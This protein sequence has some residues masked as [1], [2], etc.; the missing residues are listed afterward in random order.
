MFEFVEIFKVAP[1]LKWI[2]L[3]SADQ[4]NQKS[5]MVRLVVNDGPAMVNAFIKRYMAKQETSFTVSES[6]MR[7]LEEVLEEAGMARTLYTKGA[8]G[9]DLITLLPTTVVHFKY[10]EK[11]SFRK[12]RAARIKMF[13]DEAHQHLQV[14]EFEP[15]LRRLEWVHHLQPDHMTAFK[16]KIICFRSWKKMAE[17]IPVFERWIEESPDLLEPR[18]GLGEM[19]LF[20]EQNQRAKET[21]EQTLTVFPN[22]ALALIGLA[23][24]K[25]KL[26]EDPLGDLRKAHVMDPLATKDLIEGQFDFRSA[27]PKDLQPMTLV[28][29][30][31]DYQI[32]IKRVLERAK[33]G[34][35]PMFRPEEEGLLRFSRKDLDLHYDVL[36]TLGLEINSKALKK[37]DEKSGDPVQPGLFDG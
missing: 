31:K 7:L 24:A 33:N 13:L 2:E 3:K 35:L 17:C 26:G 36:S 12:S 14:R 16:L 34:V 21:F 30:S 23:Q 18:I 9:N 5:E 37:N 22:Q 29:I 6:Q 19:W 32:P 25:L 11:T 27:N 1:D 4:L 20:L 8:F 10:P 28:A 15:A